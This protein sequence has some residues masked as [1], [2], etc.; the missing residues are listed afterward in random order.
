[1]QGILGTDGFR[2][3]LTDGMSSEYFGSI[4]VPLI[5]GSSVIICEILSGLFAK[6]D[7]APRERVFKV[8]YKPSLGS[9][10]ALAFGRLM[11]RNKI[12]FCFQAF[13]IILTV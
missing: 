10:S 13:K 2:N 4:K 7:F 9:V 8:H 6:T 3:R 5:Q 11:V 1:M 12:L